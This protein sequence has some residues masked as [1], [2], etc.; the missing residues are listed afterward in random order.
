MPDSTLRLGRIDYLNCRPLYEGLQELPAAG[1]PALTGGNPA[2][3]NRKL[4]QGAI[5]ISPSSSILPAVSRPEDYFILPG[6]AIASVAEVRSV[7]LVSRRPPAE[8]AGAAITLTSHSLTSIFLLKIILARFQKIPLAE[9]SF[10]PGEFT[11]AKGPEAAQVIGDRALELFHRPPDGY[12]VYDLGR[13]W[14]RHTGLPFVY[15]LWLGRCAILTEKSAQLT[16]LHQ[17]LLA[18]IAGLPTRLP[19]LAKRLAPAAG[20]N[21]EQL[22][23][24]WQQAISYRLDEKALAGLELFYRCAFELGLIEQVPQ[25][26]FFP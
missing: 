24:Y 2:E 20:C 3:L 6:I 13:L 16:K 22:L 9:L 17:Q 11:P 1:L 8:L 5:D 14:H 18:V 12:Q 15:A 23:A 26:R 19:Q 7:L 21:R 25:L 10:S 4:A